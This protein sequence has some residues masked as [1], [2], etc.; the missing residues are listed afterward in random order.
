MRAP[1]AGA[2]GVAALGGRG[3]DVRGRVGGAR[4]LP[5]PEGDRGVGEMASP[6]N[7]LLG[8]L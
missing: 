7:P 2:L 8:E 5:D 1:S 4:R 3:R 6:V